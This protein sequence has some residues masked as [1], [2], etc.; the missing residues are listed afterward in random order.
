MRDHQERSNQVIKGE[1]MSVNN[2]KFVETW[3]QAIEHGHSNEWVAKQLGVP[4]TVIQGRAYF[5][6]K[7]GVN[8]PKRSG[9]MTAI[10]ISHLNDLIEQRIK[11]RRY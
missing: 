1:V 3:L 2:I 4:K 11:D 5:I 6:R 9:T 8:L 7:K 10:E